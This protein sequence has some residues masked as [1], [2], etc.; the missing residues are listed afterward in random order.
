MF[1]QLTFGAAV[2]LCLAFGSADLQAQCV[3][4]G[5]STPIYSQPINGGAYYG[6]P[7][8]NTQMYNNYSMQQTY[9]SGQVNGC[10]GG[11]TSVAPMNTGCGCNAAPVRT[12]GCGCNVAPMYSGCGGCNSAPVNMGCGGCNTA[13]VN[14][15]CGGCNSAPMN[16]GCGAPVNMGCGG[17]NGGYAQPVMSSACGCGGMVN[18]GMMMDTTVMGGDIQ[19]QATGEVMDQASPPVPVENGTK[20]E[21]KKSPAPANT[22]TSAKTEEKSE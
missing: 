15:G 13:P 14:M 10:C 22:E 2:A 3:G 6:Q 17:C 16:M 12:S 7:V 18:G 19:P 20:V 4:C 11:Y 9:T 5:G 8:Y 1:R 21:E